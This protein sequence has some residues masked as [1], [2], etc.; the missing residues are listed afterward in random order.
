MLQNAAT[1]YANLAGPKD[2]I[3]FS[4]ALKQFCFCNL[5][6]TSLILTAMFKE[7]KRDLARLV[8]KQCIDHISDLSQS[9]RVSGNIFF[10]FEN[11]R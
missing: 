9:V 2:N 5:R 3:C 8:K 7:N 11:P 1:N 4:V 10:L 6:I